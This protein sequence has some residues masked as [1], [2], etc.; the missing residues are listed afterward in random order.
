MEKSDK[1]PPVIPV[2]ILEPDAEL[3]GSIG[4]LD[5]LRLRDAE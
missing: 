3:E 4:A 5:E 1:V 2:P